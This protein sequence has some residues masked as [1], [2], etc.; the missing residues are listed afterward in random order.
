MKGGKMN[1][2]S[3]MGSKLTY[4]LVTPLGEVWIKSIDL[5]NKE[6]TLDRLLLSLYSRCGNH[7]SYL[8]E[9]P[10]NSLQKV[11]QEKG[12]LYACSKWGK[13]GS[14]YMMKGKNAIGFEPIKVDC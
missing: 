2:I 8:I 3:F 12:F 7:S 11:L 6:D 4:K 1:S 9:N 10:D 14:V 13:T 5:I